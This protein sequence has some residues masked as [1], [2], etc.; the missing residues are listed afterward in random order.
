MFFTENLIGYITSMDQHGSNNEQT[1]APR[2]C[3][4]LLMSLQMDGPNV[5]PG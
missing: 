3:W 4:W 1:L 5:L 2:L